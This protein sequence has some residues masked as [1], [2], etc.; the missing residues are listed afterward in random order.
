MPTS[1]GTLEE[2][3]LIDNGIRGDLTNKFGGIHEVAQSR[4]QATTNESSS[5]LA[6]A[7]DINYPVS[8]WQAIDLNAIVSHHRQST[9]NFWK[10]VT[11]FAKA[12]GL[13]TPILDWNMA[14]QTQVSKTFAFDSRVAY[15]SKWGAIYINSDEFIDDARRI[16]TGMLPAYDANNR[17]ALENLYVGIIYQEGFHA[18]RANASAVD[19]VQSSL[20]SQTQ[21]SSEHRVEMAEEAMSEMIERLARSPRI[22]PSGGTP[23]PIHTYEEALAFG[24]GATWWNAIRPR[25]NTEPGD[26]W[27]SPPA[28]R[29]EA[30]LPMSE[31]LYYTTFWAFYHGDKAPAA[32]IPPGVPFDKLNRIYEI[33]QLITMK[34]FFASEFRPLWT[35]QEVNDFIAPQLRLQR[36]VLGLDG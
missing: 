32:L 31:E 15:L 21:Y 14:S 16:G 4:T 1:P 30:D 6:D 8:E 13:P 17:P 24:E 5:F 20:N 34:R 12:S 19:Y 29:A 36:I 22:I 25:H 3:T 35:P 26:K 28:V 18:W 23:N 11:I 7:P 27:Y 33:E 10:G 2:P 9:R